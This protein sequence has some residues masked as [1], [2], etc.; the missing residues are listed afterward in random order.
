MNKGGVAVNA[1]QVAVVLRVACLTEDRDSKEQR[2]MLDLAVW[3]DS[4]R[5]RFSLGKAGK[6]P[7][8][9][10]LVESTYDPSAGRRIGLT[11]GQQAQLQRLTAKFVPCPECGVLMGAHPAKCLL[12]EV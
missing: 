4:E 8:L 9:T 3:A 7:E 1:E 10:D 5:S 11:A 2:A 6:V 12:G